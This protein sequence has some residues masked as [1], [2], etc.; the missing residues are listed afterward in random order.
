VLCIQFDNEKII[1]GSCDKTIKVCGYLFTVN[2]ILSFL[3]GILT[4]L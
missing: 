1:S 2:D 3:C 4:L